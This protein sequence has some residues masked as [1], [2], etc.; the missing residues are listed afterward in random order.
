MESDVPAES[1]FY[2]NLDL[3][4]DIRFL[5]DPQLFLRSITDA[6]SGA[7]LPAAGKGVC[8]FG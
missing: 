8:L 6:M 2:L 5:S 4:A 3:L 1:L 7:G